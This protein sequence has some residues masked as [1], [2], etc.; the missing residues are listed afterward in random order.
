MFLSINTV[1]EKIIVLQH[2]HHEYTN[3]LLIT[4]VTTKS[5][6]IRSKDLRSSWKTAASSKNLE[7]DNWQA[8]EMAYWSTTI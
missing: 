8:C 7:S 6:S 4:L 3:Q 5:H 2:M 1:V